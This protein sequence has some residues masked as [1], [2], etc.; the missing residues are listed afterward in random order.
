MHDLVGLKSCLKHGGVLKGYSG[1][2]AGIRDV[3]VCLCI[4]TSQN[5]GHSVT[6]ELLPGNPSFMNVPI[7]TETADTLRMYWNL[8]VSAIC[9]RKHIRYDYRLYS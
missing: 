1:K 7:C 6:C 4:T 8:V 9:I 2:V 3:Y 5:A